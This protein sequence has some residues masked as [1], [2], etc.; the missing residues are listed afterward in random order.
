MLPIIA[1]TLG[2]QSGGYVDWIGQHIHL[3]TDNDLIAK[4]A[5]YIRISQGDFHSFDGH[6]IPPPIFPGRFDKTRPF[7]TKLLEID[8]PINGY[9]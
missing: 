5:I 4:D 7:N 9:V 8:N 1:I 3:G 6:V 2:H